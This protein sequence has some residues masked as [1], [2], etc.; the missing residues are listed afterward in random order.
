[1]VGFETLVAQ[2]LRLLLSLEIMSLWR[3]SIVNGAGGGCRDV[4]VN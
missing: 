3:T 4:L 1:M 2:G